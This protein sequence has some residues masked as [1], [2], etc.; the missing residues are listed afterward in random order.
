[1]DKMEVLYRWC[2]YGACSYRAV[3]HICREGGHVPEH[4]RGEESKLIRPSPEPCLPNGPNTVPESQLQKAQ[5]ASG[6]QSREVTA[7]V[8]HTYPP[9]SHSSFS[10]P[11][12]NWGKVFLDALLFLV[13]GTHLPDPEGGASQATFSYCVHCIYLCV[14]VYS[15]LS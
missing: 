3:L 8:A 1:M 11:S 6:V 7:W 15:L 2:Q 13:R 10:S 14:K 4:C 5:H 12:P 9:P